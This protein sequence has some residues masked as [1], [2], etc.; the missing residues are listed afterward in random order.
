MI[1]PIVYMDNVDFA[2][3]KGGYR[4][5]HDSLSHREEVGVIVFGRN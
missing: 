5:V 1:E 3:L 4:A 2:H